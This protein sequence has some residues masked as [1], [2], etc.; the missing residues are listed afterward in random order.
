MN[1]HEVALEWFQSNVIELENPKVLNVTYTQ[2]GAVLMMCTEEDE[3]TY[4]ITILWTNFLNETGYQ[5]LPKDDKYV[6]HRLTKVAAIAKKP[7]WKF[8]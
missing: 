5:R 1:D 2:E 3:H 8:W 6:P 7:F 4:W